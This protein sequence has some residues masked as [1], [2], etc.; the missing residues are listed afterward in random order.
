[1]SD[2]ILKDDGTPF[3]TVES[4]KSKRTRMGKEGLDTN[5]IK[6]DGGYAL[7]FRPYER[8][9]KRVPLGTRDVLTIRPEDK[10]PNYIY[11]FVNDDGDRLRRFRDAGWEIV[12]KRDGMQIG[13]PDAGAGSQLGSVVAKTVGKEKTGYAMRIRRQYYEEDQEAKAEKIRRA[14]AD[15][16][17]EEKKPGRY[18]GVKI[19]D[20]PQY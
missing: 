6:V 12:E 9:K 10:D 15:L 18:G 19:G 2:L 16:K 14:E 17:M 5:I 11:R 7:E 13:D 4:A 8:P 1:M 20:R 3:A